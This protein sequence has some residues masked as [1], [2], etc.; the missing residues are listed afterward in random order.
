VTG[1]DSLGSRR[2]PG[3]VVLSDG[4][5]RDTF[6]RLRVSRPLTRF[7]STL[8][9]DDD[10]LDWETSIIGGGSVTHHGSESS[11]LITNGTSNNDSVVRQT[12][13][14]F[15]Y[16]AGKSHLVNLTFA[17][18][19]GV[20]GVRRRVGYFDGANGIYFE[21]HG[22]VLSFVVRSSASGSVVETK[23]EQSSWNMD[24]LDGTGASKEELY[25]ANAQNLVLDFQWLGVGRV[26]CGFYIHGEVIYAHQFQF[27]GQTQIVFMGT[28]TLPLRYSILN[29][30]AQGSA[31]TMRQICASVASEGGFD[32]DFYAPF[33]ASRGT[34]LV[35]VTTRRAI[36]SIR[37]KATFGPSSKVYRIQIVARRTSIL[38]TGALVLWELVYD[39]TFTTS[40]GALTW[41]QVN[42]QSGVEFSVHGDANAGAFTGGLVV[43][44]G[45]VPAST[46]SVGSSSIELDSKTKLPITLNIAGTTPIALTL[47]TS[48]VGVGTDP[49]CL[50]SLDFLEFS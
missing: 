36:L 33:S 49:Q 34:S 38:A 27:G 20:D 4:P 41:T 15:K 18:G 32:D 11:L 47:A 8:D 16:Q 35:T 12:R 14:Y 44:S 43:Q 40:S 50:A 7:S 10:P 28:A 30:S 46:G 6:G 23:A 39:P 31:P 29:T 21:Q 2:S 13:R 24:K 48:K 5:Q 25:S 19:A 9:Y 1:Y 45:Y 3:G 17:F 22:S 26:R 37:P 42:S